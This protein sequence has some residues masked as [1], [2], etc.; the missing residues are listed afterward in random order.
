[1]LRC[2]TLGLEIETARY[3]NT[4]RNERI[5]KLCDSG[6]IESEYHFL[7]H[8]NALNNV[9]CRMYY[10]CP[11]LLNYSDDA[12]KLKLLSC[13]PYLLGRLAKNL[14]HARNDLCKTTNKNSIFVNV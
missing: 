14:W 4:P 6:D 11:E 5:G 1:M 7:F 13:K 2:G 12:Y 3:S 10:D 9:R 8:C